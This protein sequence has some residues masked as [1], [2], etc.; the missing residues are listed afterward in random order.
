MNITGLLIRRDYVERIRQKSFI[1]GTIIAAVFIMG[2]GFLPILFGALGKATVVHLAVA[3]PDSAAQ[4]AIDKSLSKDDYS[5]TFVGLHPTGP[6]LPASLKAAMDA[7]K[8]DAAL[9]AYREPGNRLAFAYYPKKTTALE[10]SSGLQHSLLRAVILA[11][12]T[13]AR[14]SANALLN[15][16]FSVHSLNNRFKSDEEQ[17]FSQA[18]A[19]FLL[20]LLYIVVLLYG[21]YVA[22]G[23]IEEK[24]NRIMEVMIGAVR[25]SQLLAGK[26]FGIGLVALTQ[27]CIFAMSAAIAS[28]LYGLAFGQSAAGHAAASQVTPQQQAAFADAI[29]HVPWSTLVYLLIFFLL[30]FFSYAAV[31]AGMGSLLTKPE[32]VQQYAMI[33]NFPIIGAYILAI[34]GLAN[35]DMPA[36]TIC[37]MIPLLSPLLMFMRIATTTVPFWQVA[38]AIGGSLLAIWALTLLAGKLYRVGVLMYGKPPK[39]SEILRALRAPS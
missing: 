7:N 1:I 23:V 35:P 27:L 15:F 37:S 10:N 12:S 16:T 4:A 13:S 32:E 28:V 6:A 36:V 38:I 24:S 11:S 20:I 21:A 17:L 34:I 8:Y 30:G 3:V 22:Q 29:A 5:A 14:A 39:P 31:Y 9:I 2:S 26:I 18:V 19:Y 25:P 33:V